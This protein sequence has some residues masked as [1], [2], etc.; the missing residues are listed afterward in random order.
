MYV[1]TLLKTG[2]PRSHSSKSINAIII[3]ISF[4]FALFS[5]LS[6]PNDCNE[7][8]R[9]M[10]SPG[11]GNTLLQLQMAPLMEPKKNPT[12]HELEPL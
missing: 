6:S 1:V 5:R 10:L 8:S 4:H 12:Y 7:R 2:Q 9:K 3:V 11:L